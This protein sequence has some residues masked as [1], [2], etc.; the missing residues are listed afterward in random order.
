MIKGADLNSGIVFLDDTINEK[1]IRKILLELD[2]EHTSIKNRNHTLNN[3]PLR[4]KDEPV[5]HKILDL[6]GDFS[7]LGYAIK[8]HIISYGGGH[9]SNVQLMKKIDNIYG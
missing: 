1:N 7:L 4:Y 5:R 9:T 3:V 2:L 8:G 6:I